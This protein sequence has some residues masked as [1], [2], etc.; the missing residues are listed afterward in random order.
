MNASADS[1]PLTGRI[2]TY[3]T[4]WPPMALA[5]A[6]LSESRP[7]DKPSPC[8]SGAPSVLMIYVH[9]YQATIGTGAR[10]L[11]WQGGNLDGHLLKIDN[12]CWSKT[13]GVIFCNNIWAD[14]SLQWTATLGPRS[15]SVLFFDTP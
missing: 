7:R 8:A 5:C 3:S 2:F 11:F 1:N 14:L 10:C 12:Q 4:R 13:V 9:Y 15:S 6:R